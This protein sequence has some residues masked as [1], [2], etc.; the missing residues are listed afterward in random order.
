MQISV[1]GW[2]VEQ[3]WGSLFG[4]LG[5]EVSP[6][7]QVIWLPVSLHLAHLA[8]YPPN[9]NRM[10]K[11]VLDAGCQSVIIAPWP[12]TDQ[13]LW[14][15]LIIVLFS[16][17]II[18]QVNFSASTVISVGHSQTL[19]LG[20]YSLRPAPSRTPCHLAP[21]SPP[22]DDDI[23]HLV[24]CHLLASNESRILWFLGRVTCY[25][26]QPL[27]SLLRQLRYSDPQIRLILSPVMIGEASG[28][29]GWGQGRRWMKL[30]DSASVQWHLIT[31]TR[32]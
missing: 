6:F 11:A 2:S 4:C 14:Y 30:I 3:V 29:G 13:L 9:N 31:A 12:V 22:H 7:G 15:Q 26:S 20:T 32:K 23:I 27:C 21:L 10:I 25:L 24:P 28:E 17:A 16:L 5:K 8:Q 1:N 18:C 19:L